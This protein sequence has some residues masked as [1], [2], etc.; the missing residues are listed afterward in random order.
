MSIMNKKLDKVIRIKT[1]QQIAHFRKKLTMEKIKLTYQLPPYSTVIGMIHAISGFDDY[2][3]MNISIQGNFESLVF[4]LLT[5]YVYGTNKNSRGNYYFIN[6]KGK[7]TSVIKS[8][9]ETE[10]IYGLELI[11]HIQIKSK[12]IFNEVLKKLRNPLIF[13]SLGRAEDLLEI[14]EVKVVEL[15]PFNLQEVN[16]KNYKTYIPINMLSNKIFSKKLTLNKK[17]EI[18]TRYTYRNN[19]IDLREW[20]EKVDVAYIFDNSLIR[21]NVIDQDG[22]MVFLA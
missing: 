20:V 8:I 17:Y 21:S 10:E 5:N 12:K 14:K 16:K 2:E 4:N 9:S 18:A 1:Y 11:I 3:D 7:R 19:N 13:P 22:F 15:M 6:S